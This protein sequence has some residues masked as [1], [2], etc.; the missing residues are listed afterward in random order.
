MMPSKGR[1]R[2][3]ALVAMLAGAPAW[4]SAEIVAADGPSHLEATFGRM[5]V[6]VDVH[7]KARVVD[8]LDIRVDGYA[9]AV[10]RAAL[11]GLGE[12]GSFDVTRRED[13]LMVLQLTGTDAQGAYTAEFTFDRLALR[14]RRVVDTATGTV[15]QATSFGSA[16]LLD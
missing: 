11:D 8:G 12:P 4:A 5:Q 7:V 2:V 6:R 15:R 14:E 9:L 16:D 1:V 10:P 13:G 3:L